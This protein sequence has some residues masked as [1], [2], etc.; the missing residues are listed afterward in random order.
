MRKAPD[1]RRRSLRLH[2]YDYSQAG[3][4]F[5]TVCTR[6]RILL[7]GEVIDNEVRLNQLGTHFVMRQR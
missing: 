3:P 5:I 1:P 4:Y 2:G 7:F 6:N